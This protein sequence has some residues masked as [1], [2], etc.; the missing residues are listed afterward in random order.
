MKKLTRI[1]VLQEEFSVW[2][3]GVMIDAVELEGIGDEGC[4]SCHHN[5]HPARMLSPKRETIQRYFM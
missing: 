1:S 2:E 5:E 4:A 3:R